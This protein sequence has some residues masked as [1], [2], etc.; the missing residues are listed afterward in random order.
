MDENGHRSSG[1]AVEELADGDA[2]PAF[3]MLELD[4]YEDGVRRRRPFEA[5]WNVRFEQVLVHMTALIS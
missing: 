1:V 4:F 2:D 5:S 3:A